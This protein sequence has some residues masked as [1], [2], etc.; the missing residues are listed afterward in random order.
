MITVRHLITALPTLVNLG[1]WLGCGVR[2]L[3][4]DVPVLLVY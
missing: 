2:A 3:L 4:D 1:Y